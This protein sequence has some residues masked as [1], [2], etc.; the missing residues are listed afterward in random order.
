MVKYYNTRLNDVFG[1]LSDPTRRAIV[2]R[3]ARGE[4]CVGELAAPFDMSGPAVTKH[5]R[6]LE[7]AGLLGR[8]KLGRQYRCKLNPEPL[9]SA[10]AWIEKHRTF[11]DER[12]DA[13]AEY[14][15]QQATKT[16]KRRKGHE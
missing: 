12:F 2:E 1:A 8:T 13:L 4:Q 6:V 3:L 16:K 7:R 10:A 15:E 11:W 14:F 5:L 9:N